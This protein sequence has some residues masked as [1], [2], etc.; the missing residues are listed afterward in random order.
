MAF[1]PSWENLTPLFLSAGKLAVK[2]TAGFMQERGD[3]LIADSV[4][5]Y[6][7]LAAA[8]QRIKNRIAQGQAIAASAAGNAATPNLDL[9]MQ[10]ALDGE[11]QIAR[12]KSAGQITAAQWRNAGQQ[13]LYKAAGETFF[14]LAEGIGESLGRGL[15]SP[16]TTVS[17][18][19]PGSVGAPSGSFKAITT[20]P[21]V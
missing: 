7:R 3:S 20:P 5:S 2:L 8:D 9:I 21:S 12:I 17:T 6:S 1:T 15:F 10:I 14:D 16:A 11:R 13:S 18:A 4:L 19:P